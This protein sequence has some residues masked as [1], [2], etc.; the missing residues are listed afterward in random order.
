MAWLAR[1]S[2]DHGGLYAL[3]FCELACSGKNGWRALHGPPEDVIWKGADTCEGVH[4]EPGEGPLEVK[5]VRKNAPVTTE[6]M[7]KM[8]LEAGWTKMPNG[9]FCQEGESDG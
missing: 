8:M 1:D 2:K 5:I 6:Q 7:E 4:L 9:M 3:S